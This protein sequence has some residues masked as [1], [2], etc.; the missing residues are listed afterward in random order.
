MTDKSRR[1]TLR[2]QLFVSVAL[3]VFLGIFMALYFFI[4]IPQQEATFNKS[5]FRVLDEI[6]DNFNARLFGNENAFKNPEVNTAATSNNTI[7]SS[8]DLSYDTDNVKS[9][10][11]K[12]EG[13]PKKS[14]TLIRTSAAL[15]ASYTNIDT[16]AGD[17]ARKTI[18]SIFEPVI[19]IH[20][21]TF[22]SIILVHLDTTANGNQTGRLIYKSPRL[23]IDEEINI[24]SLLKKQT[25]FTFPLIHDINVEGVE[26]KLFLFPF[27]IQ[28]QK[29]LIGGFVTSHNYKVHTHSFPVTLLVVL[30][31]LLISVLFSLPF[32]KI[33]LIGP[34]ENVSVK[35]VRSV[36]AMIYIIPFFLVML[37]SAIWLQYTNNIGSDNGLEAFHEQVKTNFYNEISQ[38]IKQLKQYDSIYNNKE[39]GFTNMMANVDTKVAKKDSVSFI[40]AYMHPSIYK[41]FD[42]IFW[43][44]NK[45][46]EIAKWNFIQATPGFYEKADRKYYKDIKNNSGY[47]LP[48]DT[49]EFSIQPTLAKSTGDYTISVA[50]KSA[51]SFNT[52]RA[53]L[54]GMHGKMY[55]VFNPVVPKGYNFCI[56]NEDGDILY[57]SESERS[58][59]ENLF[60]ELNNSEAIRIAVSHKDSLK[61]D[62]VELYGENVKLLMKPLNAL[63]YYLVT[64]TDK[65]IDLLF[66]LHILAFSFFCESL[67]LIIVS[68][69]TLFYFH[70]NKQFS[71]L[72]YDEH[73][74]NFT[75][76]AP[77]KKE[78]Y[79]RILY[80]QLIIFILM[81]IAFILFNGRDWLSYILY[82]SILLPLFS[83]VGY[84]L[85]RA[86]E[87][88]NDSVSAQKKMENKFQVIALFKNQQFLK[89]FIKIIVPYVVL[90]WIFFM[91]KSNISHTE[92]FAR[93]IMVN[94]LIFLFT[95]GFPV[96]AILLSLFGLPQWLKMKKSVAD[97]GSGYLHYFI[98]SI[99]LSAVLTSV[100][101]T[102]GFILYGAGEEKS[103]SSKA[104]QIYLAEELAQHRE[105]VNK[106]V[107]NSKLEAMN[108]EPG[109]FN[110][111]PFIDSLKFSQDKGLY[112]K[113]TYL[114]LGNYPDSDKKYLF[115]N[116]YFF[117]QIT[118]YL[119]LPAEHADYF[120]NT[121]TYYWTAIP[122]NRVK[123]DSLVFHYKNN[124]DHINHSNVVL[125]ASLPPQPSL[126][127]IF[128]YRLGLV[129]FIIVLLLLVVFYKIIYS[130]SIRIFLI[131]YFD[132]T[133][134]A[135]QDTSYL[136]R[137]FFQKES[138]P[139]EGF[140]KE[141]WGTE[142]LSLDLIL[143]KE[144][145][146]ETI[147]ER[148]E[149][150]LKIG[151]LLM[152]QY[153]NIWKSLTPTEQFVLY[154]FAL[155]G[156]SNYKNVDILYSL[157]KKG[158][159]KKVKNSFVV[160]TRSF[161]NYLVAKT[162]TSDVKKLKQE[163]S[164]GGTWAHLRTVLIVL[165]LLIVIFLFIVQEDVSKRVFAV[166][167]S[168]GAAI[169]LLLKLFD[170]NIS[171]T[172]GGSSETDKK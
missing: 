5:A 48:G 172:A 164:P 137:E 58:L 33:Y 171:G 166:I 155:D 35:D 44:N 102:I 105:Y 95:A 157:Y 78:Y 87:N 154:D 71:K 122:L 61:L 6:A 80:Y 27:R 96:I 19:S 45:G 75:K 147:S 24:D 20:G 37:G 144:T 56:I 74:L 142:T 38:S 131:G 116:S 99:M 34:Q 21:N 130:S 41:N 54:I 86:V 107:A 120:S 158:I 88:Y 49:T 94:S 67:M 8:K 31:I 65:K 2:R 148:E 170:R 169:P 70:S 16:P 103:L 101:P 63:P 143:N 161:R 9:K 121:N 69:I 4:Y 162:G 12:L 77:H 57:H 151:N 76:P 124:S 84:Y 128:N 112:L 117:R 90:I 1:A 29:F 52:G 39:I 132:K 134:G 42:G 138:L 97:D 59:Q 159:I 47:Y 110:D 156:F 141:F 140:E 114:T 3:I 17:S 14:D 168:V 118:Q 136:D 100:M 60:A 15:F 43:V 146:Y 32:L 64:Y 127:S 135:E 82:S 108:N 79:K 55:S 91:I 160:M 28:H 98:I 36:I 119:F 18:D 10:L 89:S 153:E 133:P 111:T 125:T 109:K 7:P 104:R 145:G 40:D 152:Q 50:I 165:I 13:L 81:T 115:T 72:F 73:D 62:N 11:A 26:Y 30:A 150:I 106:K 149:S 92:F 22:E 139:D 51:S 46:Q 126:L 93:K 113:G 23:N 68:L 53:I 163:I 25:V 85:I 167:T 123:K 66:I 129:I 83:V